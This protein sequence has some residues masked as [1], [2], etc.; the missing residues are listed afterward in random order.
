M[1]ELSAAGRP[2]RIVKVEREGMWCARREQL[3]FSALRAR[4]FGEFPEVEFATASMESAPSPF[5]V[6]PKT[7]GRP[8][9]DLWAEDRRLA[10]WVAEK[11]GDF[12]RRLAGVDWRVVPGVVTPQERVGGFSAWFVRFFAPLIEDPTLSHLERARIEELLEAMR[13]PPEAGRHTALR[14]GGHR[15]PT[16][17]QDAGHR[18]GS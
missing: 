17:P 10:I 1:F 5:T 11:I 4:G 13:Q 18:F 6:M 9:P 14:P 8:W 3:A 16:R 2:A 7:E 15:A 12:L